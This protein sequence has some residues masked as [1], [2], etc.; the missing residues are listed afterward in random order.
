MGHFVNFQSK[1]VLI[2]KHFEP[3]YNTNSW[4]FTRDLKIY[5]SDKAAS[6]GDYNFFAHYVVL[7]KNLILLKK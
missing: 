1:V 5:E 3:K 7:D 4:L 6:L 2:H